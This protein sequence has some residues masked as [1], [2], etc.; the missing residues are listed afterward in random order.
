MSLEM[1]DPKAF[2]YARRETRIPMEVGVQISGHSAARDPETTFTENVSVR[3]ARVWSTQ[4]WK[5]NDQL[6]IATLPGSFHSTARVAYCQSVPGAGFAL[7]LEFIKPVG[8]WV[9]ADCVGN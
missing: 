2:A 4:R 5:M 3:G 1:G 6:I 8:T 9:V 7:G